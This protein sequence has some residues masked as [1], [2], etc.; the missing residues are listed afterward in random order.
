MIL[1]GFLNDLHKLRREHSGLCSRRDLVKSIKK[2]PKASDINLN[3]FLD[4]A[5]KRIIQ[6]ATSSN[7]L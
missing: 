1:I 7:S 2:T 3:S 6:S 5:S 4:F